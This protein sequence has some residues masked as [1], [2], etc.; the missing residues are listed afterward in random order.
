MANKRPGPK[1]IRI[2]RETKE[3]WFRN[4]TEALVSA[5]PRAAGV[6]YV[7]PLCLG[8]S[9][10]IEA[11]TVEDVPPR[12]VGGRPLVLTCKP[13]NDYGGSELD[14]HWSNVRTIERPA[15]NLDAHAIRL[16]H[17][18]HNVSI[19]ESESAVLRGEKHI[20][21][22]IESGRVRLSDGGIESLT[23]SRGFLLLTSASRSPVTRTLP[24][25]FGQTVV[26]VEGTCVRRDATE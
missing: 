11:F 17:R 23:G 19:V 13:C 25:H 7:C 10:S 26:G 22:V 18:R 15:Q 8:A 16:S 4:G 20:D 21:R 3:R 12:K 9:Q 5:F 1:R 2:R 14:V 24:A 6:G